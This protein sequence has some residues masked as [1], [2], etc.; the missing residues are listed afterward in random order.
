MSTWISE[1]EFCAA[2]PRVLGGVQADA[3][4][5]P[6]RSGAVAA[7]Y[8]SYCLRIPF[9]PYG[10]SCPGTLL[11][12]DTVSQSGKTLRKAQKKLEKVGNTVV[13]V[14]VYRQMQR[15]HFWYEQQNNS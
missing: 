7:V 15:L 9:V 6:G 1:Q 2:L 4:T 12:I 3:V 11:L 8:A 5:G 14:A 10:Q 13:A